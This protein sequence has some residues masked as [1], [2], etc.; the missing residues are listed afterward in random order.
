MQKMNNSFPSGSTWRLGHLERK[1]TNARSLERKESFETRYTSVAMEDESSP[2]SRDGD[3]CK[4]DSKDELSS[5]AL[6]IQEGNG[7][8][9]VNYL[10]FEQQH[11]REEFHSSIPNNHKNDYD[12]CVYRKHRNVHK[13]TRYCRDDHVKVNSG[14][15]GS[16]NEANF[17]KCP[18]SKAVL[19]IWFPGHKKSDFAPVARVEPMKKV[20]TIGGK[21][22]PNVSLDY[23]MG[24]EPDKIHG[25]GGKARKR[26]Y[27]THAMDD[28]PHAQMHMDSEDDNRTLGSA[29]G[30]SPLRDISS[31]NTFDGCPSTSFNTQEN[32]DSQVCMALL[33]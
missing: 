14:H 29:F 9:K 6:N 17:G 21:C 32:I 12:N 27:S 8:E 15:S 10:S 30:T 13:Q 33:D 22:T 24:F 18:P 26:L 1:R 28:I 4:Q 2:C 7:R 11:D 5:S 31:R 3:G 16:R 19:P 20:E 25:S 23:T